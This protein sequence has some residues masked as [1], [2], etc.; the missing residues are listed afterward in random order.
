[1]LT[2]TKLIT[3][4]NKGFLDDCVK[5]LLRYGTIEADKSWETA[6]GYYK[7]L[8]RVYQIRLHNLQWRVSMLNGEVREV[9]YEML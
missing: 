1:V 5:E 3:A 2:K 7:G 9:G 6:E 4:F 8:T